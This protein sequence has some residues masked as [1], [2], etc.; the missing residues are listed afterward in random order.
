MGHWQTGAM[1]SPRGEQTVMSW[2]R[3]SKRRRDSPSS[4][5][6]HHSKG[7]LVVQARLEWAALFINVRSFRD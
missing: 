6:V 7:M 3:L 4:S 1:F 5:A 2:K